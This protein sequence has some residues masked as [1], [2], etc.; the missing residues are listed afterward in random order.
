[1]ADLQIHTSDF[2][3]EYADLGGKRHPQGAPSLCPPGSQVN[4]RVHVQETSPS[5]PPDLPLGR[6]PWVVDILIGPDRHE[7]EEEV[8]AS[9]PKAS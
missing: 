6:K 8:P 5:R 7:G 4:D 2:S 9:A 3:Q 1:M